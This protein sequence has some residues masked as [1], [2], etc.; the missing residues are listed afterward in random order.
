MKKVIIVLSFLLISLAG[1]S[2][3]FFEPIPQNLFKKVGSSERIELGTFKWLPRPAGEL[4]ATQWL[5]NK[6]KGSL[7]FSYF[8]S[9]G[10]GAGMQHYKALADGTAFN[11]YGFN[12]LVII[13]EN[14]S[15]AVTFCGFGVLNCGVVYNFPLK[16][17]GLL[18]G[19][20]YKF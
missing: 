18:T 1:F 4:T 11:N 2:Q 6:E 17:F 15:A 3:K 8:N 19:I 12:A 16:T 14:I 10:L 20:Q 7:D 9:L 5:W 13:G